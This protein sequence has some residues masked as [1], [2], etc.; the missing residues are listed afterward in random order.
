MA[1]WEVNNGR[2]TVV[3]FS[4]GSLSIKNPPPYLS[5]RRKFY[6]IPYSNTGLGGFIEQDG[7]KFHT[8]SWMEVHSQTTFNDL[9]VEKKPFQ[10][11]FVEEIISFEMPIEEF[12]VQEEIVLEVEREFVEETIVLSTEVFEEVNL[13]ENT[14]EPIIEESIEFWKKSIGS[15]G[16]IITEL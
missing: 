2:K 7:K 6:K 14:P 15:S 8:P 16:S 12:T 10:E 4:E 11:V 3:I 1:L 5:V 9:S 13:P